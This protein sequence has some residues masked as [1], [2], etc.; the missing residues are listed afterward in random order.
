MVSSPQGLLG[1]P[2]LRAPDP[3]SDLHLPTGR[4]ITDRRTRRVVAPDRRNIAFPGPVEIVIAAV[5][6]D[7]PVDAAGR[8]TF[9]VDRRTSGLAD[10]L[11]RRCA[12]RRDGDGSSARTSGA[13]RDT[14]RT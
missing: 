7:Q 2:V 9:G 5:S 3:A 14:W 11:E 13:E 4:T 12:V 6:F 8:A 10:R 1:I